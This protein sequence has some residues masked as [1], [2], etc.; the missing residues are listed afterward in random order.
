M[1]IRRYYTEEEVFDLASDRLGVDDP[2]CNKYHEIAQ[3][4][5]LEYDEIVNMYYDER[6]E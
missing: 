1:K 6:T 5:D 3:L 2:N 4:M